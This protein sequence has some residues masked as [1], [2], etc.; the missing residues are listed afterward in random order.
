[1]SIVDDIPRAITDAEKKLVE[2]EQGV[3]IMKGAGEDTTAQQAQLDSL[4]ARIAAYRKSLRNIRG[5]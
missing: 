4:K 3:L 1:M 5:F 2:A